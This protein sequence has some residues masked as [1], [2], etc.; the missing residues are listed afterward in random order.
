VL[1]AY[2]H[3][4][5][6][7]EDAADWT[8]EVRGAATLARNL[9]A[10]LDDAL[11]FRRLAT[12]RSDVPLDDPLRQLQW[13]GPAVSALDTLSERLGMQRIAERA[14]RLADMKSRP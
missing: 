13:R 3:I 14:Q 4:D 10:G 2:E 12:L 1:A 7:P 9:R 5:A 8:I 6:I 11:L